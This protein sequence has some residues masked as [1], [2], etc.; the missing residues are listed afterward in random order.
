MDGTVWRELRC[1]NTI[2]I[3]LLFQIYYFSF[4]LDS[5]FV[6]SLY[7][8]N[9]CACLYTVSLYCINIHAYTGRKRLDTALQYLLHLVIM[10]SQG[11]GTDVAHT[12]PF[13]ADEEDKIWFTGVF[14]DSD[15]KSLHVGKHFCVHEG[16]S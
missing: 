4:I 3:G 6:L 1:P 16:R 14:S 7:C 12:A 2:I 10:Y 8:I 13:T 11:I 9:I 15:P 5:R